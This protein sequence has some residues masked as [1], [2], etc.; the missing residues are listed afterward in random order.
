MFSRGKGEKKIECISSTILPQGRNILLLLI[1][2]TEPNPV[3]VVDVFIDGF[4]LDVLDFESVNSKLVALIQRA[5]SD[6]EKIALNCLLLL[7]VT[8]FRSI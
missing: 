6:A 8:D 3:R 4:Q 2:R 1:S 5:E 7:V